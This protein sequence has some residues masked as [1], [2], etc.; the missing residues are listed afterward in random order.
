MKEIIERLRMRKGNSWGS[1]QEDIHAADE[2]EKLCALLIE[3]KDE[4]EWWADAHQCCEGS[5][6]E[7]IEK[8][9][10][11]LNLKDKP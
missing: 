5:A 9:N 7:V 3:A 4:I 2:I 11:A 8:I 6:E 10:K 1:W